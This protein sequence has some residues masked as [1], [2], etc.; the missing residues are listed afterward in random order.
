MKNLKIDY[1]SQA[2]RLKLRELDFMSDAELISLPVGSFMFF[3]VECYENFFGIL[4]KSNV[5]NKYVWFEQSP[6]SLINNQKL[7]WILWRFCIIGFNSRCYDL[8]IIFL[9][10]KGASCSELKQATNFIIQGQQ[11]VYQFEKRYKLKVPTELNHIDL[12]ELAPLKGSL[13]LYGGRLHFPTIQDLPFPEDVELSQ[14]DAHIVKIYCGNDVDITQALFIKLAPEI[15]LRVDMS[16]KYGVDLRSKSDAQI[17]EAVL[18]SELEKITGNRVTR[19]TFQPNKTIRYNAPD[20]IEFKYQN[21][22]NAFEI[23]KNLEF[24]LNESGSPIEPEE[25]KKLTVTIGQTTYNLGMGGLHSMESE[26]SYVADENTLLT[27]N[28]VASYY[29]NIILNQSLYPEHL[30]SQFLDVYRTIVETRIDA[31]GKAKTSDTEEERNHF[32]TI[33]DS[34][35]ITINGSFGKFGNKYSVL[36]SPQLLLQVTITGQLCLLML[37]EMLDSI[38]I[39]VV[40]GNTDG[41][42]SIYQKERHEEVRNVI[43]LWEQ[44]TNF[45][46]EETRYKAVYSRDVNSYIAIKENDE[47]KTKGAFS[48]TKINL[49]KNPVNAVCLDAVIEY[50]KNKTSIEKTIREC[51]DIRRFVTT[52]NV[53]GGAHKL[54]N[55]RAI[56]KNLSDDEKVNLL[57]KKGF[58]KDNKG[59]WHCP[60]VKY[61]TD[62]YAFLSLEDAFNS[63]SLQEIKFDDSV[64]LGKVVR[65][66]YAKDETG[67]IDYILSGNKV[68]K[69][70]GAKPLMDLP[71]SLPDDIDYDWYINEAVSLLYDCNGL[72]R[73]K[74]LSFF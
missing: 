40:S 33:A 12:I 61:S 18:K 9:S 14:S 55:K 62:H 52:R 31:K 16:Q 23:V 2:Q 43:K 53:K 21:L 13:K 25:L 28:D 49:S 47:V 72:K 71:E 41:I 60:Y 26:V 74:Q 19:P 29:P 7:A 36:Y 3:D 6:V 42:V 11:T 50:L 51:S 32:K 4:F 24:I 54:I 57:L 70:D 73:A 45:V 65:W 15:Q 34:L 35:K 68:P 1:S 66:Y 48:G 5:N 37:I 10:L 67:T 69:S 20:F 59:Y 8:P 63:C 58:T 44:K 22:K 56:Y 64:Y 30:G 39:N 38:G 27:D 17:A 46:T